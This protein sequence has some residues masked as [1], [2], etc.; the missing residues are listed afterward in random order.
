MQAYNAVWHEQAPPDLEGAVATLGLGEVA[1]GGEC[2]DRRQTTE[3]EGLG[4]R[5]W[6]RG[7]DYGGE[8]GT[9]PAERAGSLDAESSGRLAAGTIVPTRR[10]TASR[11][12]GTRCSS[13]ASAAG[14]SSCASAA[15]GAPRSLSQQ[16]ERHLET[17]QLDLEAVE[18][19]VN[20][21]ATP[22][23]RARLRA[24]ETNDSMPT[25]AMLP[26]PE[27]D[28]PLPIYEVEP[29]ETRITLSCSSESLVCGWL[30]CFA[31]AICLL[32]ASIVLLGLSFLPYEKT[33]V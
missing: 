2:G 14:C 12:S 6:G 31:F 17:A 16:I 9:T 25:P 33:A 13:R 20:G 7:S 8:G 27:H 15:G 29:L 19:S 3:G 24:A 32:I 21:D 22:A 5:G 26:A 23:Q 1:A 28:A 10:S 18:A 4:R 11:T 30:I